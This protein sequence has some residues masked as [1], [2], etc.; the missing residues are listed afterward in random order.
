MIKIKT[1]VT[2][3]TYIGSSRYSAEHSI[4]DTR[5]DEF[6][7]SLEENNN[8]YISHRTITTNSDNSTLRTE[9]VYKEDETRK[10][11]VEKRR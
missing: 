2:A 3:G 8:I 4:H 6:L 1:I 10:V 9:I 7:K 5:I 11:L